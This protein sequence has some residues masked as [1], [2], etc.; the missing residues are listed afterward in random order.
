MIS[1]IFKHILELFSFLGPRKPLEYKGPKSDKEAFKQDA[2]AIVGDFK[3]VS[4]D[5]KLTAEN[6]LSKHK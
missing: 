4:Q 3:Q 2:K 1:N 6:F 5:L